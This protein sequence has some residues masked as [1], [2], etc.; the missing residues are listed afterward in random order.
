MTENRD[1]RH[2]TVCPR[3]FAEARLGMF[4]HWGIY[5]LLEHG[6][7]PLFREFLNLSEYKKLMTHF[8]A[9]RYDPRSWAGLAAESGMSYMV[10][11]TKHHDGFCLWDTAT[12]DY[13]AVNSAAGR[14]LLAQYVEACRAEGLRIG[15][16][17]SIP[18]WSVPAFFAGPESDPKAYR[19]FIKLIWDQLEE[20]VTGYG[21]IDLLW[22]DGNPAAKPGADELR[23]TEL[24]EMLRS[25]QPDILIN[26]RLPKPKSGGDWG[27]A[28]PEQRLGE[29]SLTPWEMCLTSTRHFWGYHRCHE[30]PSLWH[31][32]RELLEMFVSC[33]SRGGRLLLNVGPR[34]DGSLPALF[35]E[36]AKLLGKWL[37]KNREAI[38]DALPANFEFK[39][40]GVLTR[41]ENRLFLHFFYWPGA[42]Y[43]MPGFNER[44][45]SARLL[46]DGGSINAL[47][48]S[49][50]VVLKDMP[51]E[52]PDIVTVVELTFDAPPTAHPWAKHRLHNFPM[53]GL[54]KWTE[55]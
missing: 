10:L 2:V 28:T 6:E 42:E 38:D 36:R 51:K 32:E 43:S 30:D 53:P 49:H 50:R 7:Q 54:E 19:R 24:V 22:F 12:T 48:E 31:S 4:I 29:T 11:T 45:I 18:D 26:D 21:R 13:N 55:L 27:Y 3:W 44:L 33:L 15:F 41:K 8:K 47:Q 16:Y 37:G 23:S 17:Y 35:V 40:G 14:D 1:S 46:A 20:L 52:A 5:S 9:E 34:G 25:H 39:Y